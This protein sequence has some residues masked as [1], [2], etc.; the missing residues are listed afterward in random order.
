MVIAHPAFDGS[1]STKL[2]ANDGEALGFK[3]KTLK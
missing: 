2:N 1:S 3:T